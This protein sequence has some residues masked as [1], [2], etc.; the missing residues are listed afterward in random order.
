MK[1]YLNFT[2]TKACAKTIIATH[3]SS[4]SALS[5]YDGVRD[6]RGEVLGYRESRAQNTIMGARTMGEGS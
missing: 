4:V 2:L 6:C 1:P 3:L 5:E